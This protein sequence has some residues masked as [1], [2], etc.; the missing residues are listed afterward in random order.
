MC[1]CIQ[2][3]SPRARS[4]NYLVGRLGPTIFFRAGRKRIIKL[5]LPSRAMRNSSQTN[6]M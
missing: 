2:K 6:P 5:R 3:D 4:L 1:A